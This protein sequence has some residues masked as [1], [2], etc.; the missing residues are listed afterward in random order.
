MT[1]D[2]EGPFTGCGK[3]ET[4]TLKIASPERKLGMNFK[5]TVVTGVLDDEAALSLRPICP[6]IIKKIGD[7]PVTNGPQ[8]GKIVGSIKEQGG[9]EFPITYE[10]CLKIYTITAQNVSE[11][12][13]LQYQAKGG[14][15][16]I[17]GCSGPSQK[18]GIPIGSILKTVN[19]TVVGDYNQVTPII[20]EAKKQNC[21]V[22]KIG[23]M[24]GDAQSPSPTAPVAASAP[25]LPSTAVP[26]PQELAKGNDNG[27]DQAPVPTPA[28]AAV[29]ASIPVAYSSTARSVA[30]TETAIPPMPFFEP[31]HDNKACA[32]FK[33]ELQEH[34]E[35]KFTGASFPADRNFW[36]NFQ[37]QVRLGGPKAIA[38][39]HYVTRASHDPDTI[40]K[41]NQGFMGAFIDGWEKMNPHTVTVYSND[42]KK[43]TFHASKGFWASLDAKLG[44]NTPSADRVLRVASDREPEKQI[45]ASREEWNRVCAEWE[46][47][48]NL[49]QEEREAHHKKR[50]LEI[51]QNSEQVGPERRRSPNTT[52]MMNASPMIP[53]PAQP[54]ANAVSVSTQWVDPNEI[55][56]LREVSIQGN[57]TRTPPFLSQP[58]SPL[59]GECQQP[60]PKLQSPPTCPTCHQA[61][62]QRRHGTHS[63]QASHRHTPA[64]DRYLKN[65]LP[66]PQY[67][68]YNQSPQ[69]GSPDGRFWASFVKEWEGV[70]TDMQRTRGSTYVL[71][72][73]VDSRDL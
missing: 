27:G 55:I 50:W 62:P 70:A 14:N 56:H 29:D 42:G 12:L 46:R 47:D 57:Q 30:E 5:G 9:T 63:R 36:A 15:V 65:R 73:V 19:N 35:G 21:L 32:L 13:G 59:C 38:S 61:S 66:S 43:R 58:K 26:N 51:S 33:Q 48:Q 54:P 53:L 24:P 64:V 41:V 39:P 23:V 18:S 28:P 2:D 10:R 72:G 52:P 16:V 25:Q 17:V 8:L 11:S 40:V 3:L 71:D 67:G 31:S 69:Q 68:Q 7:S 22:Y 20:V 49:T 4:Y 6:F 34:V 45:L 60:K 37:Q 1:Q 44:Q